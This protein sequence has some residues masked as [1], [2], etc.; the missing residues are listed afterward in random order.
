MEADSSA[1]FLAKRESKLGGA[2]RKKDFKK[3]IDEAEMAKK[4]EERVIRIRKQ[5]REERLN[6]R[7]IVSSMVRSK[8][9]AAMLCLCDLRCR[10][11]L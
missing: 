8:F 2:A 10:T 4:R 11:V 6:K 9:N 7:R 5:R 1:G 3:G